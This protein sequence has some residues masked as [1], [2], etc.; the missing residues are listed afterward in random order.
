MSQKEKR[1]I[2]HARHNYN[3]C[4]LQNKTKGYN[5]WVITM[6]FYS[7]MYYVY[8]NIFPDNIIIHGKRVYCV[9]FH[10]YYNKLLSGLRQRTNKHSATEDLVNELIPA[11]YDD[12][13][14][15]VEMC[16]NARYFNYEMSDEHAKLALECLERIKAHCDPPPVAAPVAETK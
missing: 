15:L 14:T 12:F 3:A 2:E 6:A 11:V 13:S 9:N 1:L 4:L 5:D 7:A 8:Y 16:K 10:F